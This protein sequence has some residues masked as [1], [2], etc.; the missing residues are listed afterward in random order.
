MVI[1]IVGNIHQYRMHRSIYANF[2]QNNSP[3]LSEVFEHGYLPSLFFPR[4]SYV[5]EFLPSS[6]TEFGRALYKA[7]ANLKLTLTFHHRR[8]YSLDVRQQ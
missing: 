2:L 4:L 3:Q 1:R 5:A 6:S 7:L 8:L